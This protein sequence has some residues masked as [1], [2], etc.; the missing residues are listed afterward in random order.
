MFW[1]RHLEKNGILIAACDE[2]L[3][4][5]TLKEGEVE[6]FVNP[7]FYGAEKISEKGL[8]EKLRQCTSANLVGSDAVSVGI[9][10]GII[11]QKNVKKISGIPHAQF[12]L[13]TI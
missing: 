5:K 11:E 6:F 13:V 4:G 1:K 2:K 3:S 10:A 8:I 12:V 9:K 7:R